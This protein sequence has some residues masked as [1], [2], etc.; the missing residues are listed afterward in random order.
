MRTARSRGSPS[1]SPVRRQPRLDGRHDHP[2]G[3]RARHGGDGRGSGLFSALGIT[4]SA[5]FARYLPLGITAGASA[6]G[7][8][9]G[10][11]SRD[12]VYL[13]L[14]SFCGLPLAGTAPPPTT[15]GRRRDRLAG[16]LNRMSGPYPP[17]ARDSVTSASSLVVIGT[18]RGEPEAGRTP[19]FAQESAKPERKEVRTCIGPPHSRSRCHC[20][21]QSSG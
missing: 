16:L 7:M 15:G 8:L 6:G 9:K 21:S 12:L 10:L 14:L 13:P 1:R 11:G 18:T 2:R 5:L 19:R 4:L 17:S 3:P 20:P